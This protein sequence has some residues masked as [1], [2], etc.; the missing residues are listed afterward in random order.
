MTLCRSS[1][2]RFVFCLATVVS[3]LAL[4]FCS[5][6]LLLFT[7]LGFQ[8]ALRRL[9]APVV[10][11]SHVVALST[12]APAT[13]RSGFHPPGSTGHSFPTAGLQS[14]NTSVSSYSYGD[15]H[16][17]SYFDL[18]TQRK[19]P[20]TGE[21]FLAGAH[22]GDSDQDQT[23]AAPILDG[24]NGQ[25]QSTGSIGDFV[26]LSNDQFQFSRTPS[27]RDPQYWVARVCSIGANGLARLQWFLETP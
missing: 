26:F 1:D 23:S 7:I 6:C 27:A 22:D 3:T 8:E 13:G 4:L 10:P 21:P 2:P 12:P 11:P 14:A 16:I 17:R 25:S 15:H 9:A 5:V 19:P 20:R 18:Q 24:E